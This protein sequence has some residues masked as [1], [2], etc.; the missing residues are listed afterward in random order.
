M[1]LYIEVW[2]LLNHGETGIEYIVEA[3]FKTKSRTTASLELGH[4][5]DFLQNKGW[6]LPE[7]VLKTR[8]IMERY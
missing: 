5:A 3:S 1:E 6:F 4:L 2:T 7:G 8:L